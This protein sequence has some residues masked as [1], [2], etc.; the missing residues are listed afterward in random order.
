MAAGTAMDMFLHFPTHF[1]SVF[2]V[3][4][5]SVSIVLISNRSLSTLFFG[6]KN[7]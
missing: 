2:S 1:S 4:M 3:H 7:F 6:T 5:F